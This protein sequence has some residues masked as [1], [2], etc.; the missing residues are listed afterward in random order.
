MLFPSVLHNF[1]FCLLVLGGRLCRTDHATIV[2]NSH[3]V[4]QSKDEERR[5]ILTRE[6][7]ALLNPNTRTCPVFFWRRSA[8]ITKAIYNRLPVLNREGGTN[9]W[10]IRFGTIFHSSNDS[11]L[12]LADG[13]DTSVPLYEAKMFDQYNHRYGSY[14]QLQDGERSHMLPEVSADRLGDPH[15]RAQAFW[16]VE[17]REVDTVLSGKWSARWLLGFRNITSAGRGAQPFISIAKVWV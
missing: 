11:D 3:N 7:I 16:F 1:K 10:E 12:F 9:E 17:E 5:F 13:T 8:E 6:D 14:D 15:Y 4:E 2:F